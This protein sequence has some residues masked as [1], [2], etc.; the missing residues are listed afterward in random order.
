VESSLNHCSAV[1]FVLFAIAILFFITNRAKRQLW[2]LLKTIKLA[3][4]LERLKLWLAVS[5]K[6]S[7]VW[8]S[9]SVC[10][11]NFRQAIALMRLLVNFS[12]DS[13]I[14][15]LA[16]WAKRQTLACSN[17]FMHRLLNLQFVLCSYQSC[18]NWTEVNLLP[19]LSTEQRNNTSKSSYQ[20]IDSCWKVLTEVQM[21]GVECAR[22]LSQGVKDLW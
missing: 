14:L 2:R 21:G 8:K 16:T 6:L 12:F 1:I 9:N 13:M 19:L 22:F 18:I 10:K 4:I 17:Y 15:N 7:T 11:Y 5:L 20:C 3:E